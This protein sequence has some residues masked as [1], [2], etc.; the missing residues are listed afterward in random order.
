MEKNKNIIDQCGD[1]SKPRYTSTST[2][3]ASTDKRKGKKET[4]IFLIQHIQS[5]GSAVVEFNL[6]RKRSITKK[7]MCQMAEVPYNTANSLYLNKWFKG[8]DDMFINLYYTPLERETGLNINRT[9]S[10]RILFDGLRH[11]KAVFMSIATELRKHHR[12]NRDKITPS[13]VKR[14]NPEPLLPF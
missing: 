13:L 5:N 11:N 14:L 3:K 6:N 1:F 4:R 7:E 2:A 12:S 10:K 9:D 8:F